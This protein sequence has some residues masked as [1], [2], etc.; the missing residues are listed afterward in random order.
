MARGK[1]NEGAL[2]PEEKLAQALVPDWERPYKVPQNW[3]WTTVDKVATVVTG[4][5]P[6][7]NHPEYYG[8]TFPFYKP[9]DLD[10]GRYVY[11]ASEYLSDAGKSVSR[12]IPQDSTAVCCIG[13]IGKCGYITREGTTNQQINSVIPR[14]N[15]LYLYYFLNTDQFINELWS[16]ASATTI[17][18]V[19]KSKLEQ[20]YFPLAPLAEQ[21]RIVDRI[22]NLFAKLDEAKEK[23]QSVLDNFEVRKAAILHEAF[24]GELTAKWRVE[25]GV[26]VDSWRQGY[27]GEFCEV[28]PKKAVT[29]D[30]PDDL[31]V[32]FVPMPALSD[33]LGE[34]TDPQ[35]RKLKEV[36]T[37]FTNFSEGDVVFA[38]I[39]PC[40]E[41]G[42][43]A[44]V[45]PLVNNLGFGTTEFYVLRC[46]KMLLNRYLY[47]LVR[48]QAFRA[49][50]KSVM[51]GAVGQQRVPKSFLEDYP[52]TIPS[53]PEQI[54]IV[55]ILD[56]L[57]TKEQ[58]AK[59]A[60]EAVLEKIDLLKKSILARAFR[61]ELDTNDPTEESALELLKQVL[62]EDVPAVPKKRSKSIPKELQTKLSTEL[63]RKIVKLYFKQETDS[64][65]A[66]ELLSVSSKKFEVMDSLRNLEQRGILKKLPNG[67][68][69]LL[70]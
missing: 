53:V 33:I 7:K 5:T 31:E 38:K 63:E 13:S 51:T 3:C 66:E 29:K 17:S 15:P 45:G 69:R 26:K 35:V 47:H 30:F 50:A 62:Q 56:S 8:G 57:F 70:E 39:T 64:L 23:A 6:S 37:G 36:R 44:V 21:Q 1:K 43:S 10:A 52:L 46:S 2:N 14:F 54:E 32:T 67:N 12:I 11:E 59:E 49:D 25:H 68:Y 58:Q 65:P 27:L 24:I 48:S 55:R 22:E 20:C 60:A 34:I 61:G 41:N 42:K 9:S 28:N 18:I 19:N 40:M 4:G 16:K